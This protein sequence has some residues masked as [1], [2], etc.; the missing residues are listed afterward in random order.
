MN[1]NS[2][3]VKPVKN[4]SSR[5]PAINQPQPGKIGGSVVKNNMQFL[6]TF[7][8]L[9]AIAKECEELVENEQDLSKKEQ[10]RLSLQRREFRQLYATVK[11]SRFET[12]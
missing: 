12:F 3:Q 9:A 8:K 5:A 10:V 6:Q 4:F 11:N 2:T 7:L 1:E